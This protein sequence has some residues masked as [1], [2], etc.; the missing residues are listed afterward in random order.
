MRI[1]LPGEELSVEIP[2]A[3]IQGLMLSRKAHSH[4]VQ[5]EDVDQ[6]VLMYVQVYYYGEDGKKINEPD[7][8]ISPYMRMISATNEKFAD[9]ESGI[10]LCNV[11]EEYIDGDL[12]PVLEGR[13]YAPQFDLFRQ[14]MRQPTVIED[15]KRNHILYAYSQGYL[16]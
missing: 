5:I 1:D 14:M 6:R 3:N 12:N 4:T 2:P 11:W 13:N 15:M 8:G 10:P 7:R 9:V 16:D